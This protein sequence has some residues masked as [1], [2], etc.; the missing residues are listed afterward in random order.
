[1]QK[2]ALIALLTKAPQPMLAYEMVEWVSNLVLVWT[3]IPQRTVAFAKSLAVWAVGI[4]TETIL[5]SQEI[6]EGKI[7]G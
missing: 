7:I 1:M 4:K 6:S 2:L 3:S 5:P